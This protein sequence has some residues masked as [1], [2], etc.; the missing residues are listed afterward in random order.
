MALPEVFLQTDGMGA[1]DEQ[2]SNLTD[3]SQSWDVRINPFG[4][5]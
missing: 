3:L 5:I 4:H 1:T 2:N